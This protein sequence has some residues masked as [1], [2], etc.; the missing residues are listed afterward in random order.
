[1]SRVNFLDKLLDGVAV[2]WKALGDVVSLRRG[3]VMS[4]E[5][6]ISPLSQ[7]PV[8]GCATVRSENRPIR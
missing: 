7:L 6:L 4:K 2:E 5:Y 8:A 3:R 1:M